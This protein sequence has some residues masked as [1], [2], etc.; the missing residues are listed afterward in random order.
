MIKIE[1][2]LR[3]TQKE[4]FAYLTDKFKSVAV[5]QDNNFVYVPGEAPILLVAHLDTVHKKPVKIICYSRS[6]NILMSPQGIGGDDRCGVYAI[7]KIYE[8]AIVKP[9]LVFTCDEEIGGYGAEAFA[10]YMAEEIKKTTINPF[11]LIVEI[12]RK[13]RKDAVYYNCANKE[14]E[15]YIT[16]KGF[17]TDYGSFSDISIIAPAIGIA[18]VNLSSGYYNA[19]TEHEYINR[20]ELYNVIH[21]VETIVQES[22]SDK[23]PVYEY[24]E[25]PKTVY[26][27]YQYTSPYYGSKFWEEDLSEEIP[28]YLQ[29]AYDFLAGIYGQAEIDEYRKLYGNSIINELYE[30]EIRYQQ[31]NENVNQYRN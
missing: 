26:N 10:H 24:K 7:L 31:E 21:K 1:K 2:L 6:G 17:V 9:H 18:A 16:A 23:V 25:D 22:V 20:Q 15:D 14:F 11:K 3:K 12:D 13:G 27:K 28:L 30:E 19:H 4:L 8:K 29:A 5:S